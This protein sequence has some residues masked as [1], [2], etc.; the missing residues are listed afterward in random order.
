MT[1]YRKMQ[2]ILRLLHLSVTR[3]SM[4]LLH[5]ASVIQEGMTVQ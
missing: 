1:G 4:M 3:R 5:N 2:S